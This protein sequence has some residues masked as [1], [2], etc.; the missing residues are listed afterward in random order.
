[1]NSH[2]KIHNY[3]AAV[4][5]TLGALLVGFSFLSINEQIAKELQL[6]QHPGGAG[7]SSLSPEARES[8]QQLN[9]QAIQNQQQRQANSAQNNSAEGAEEGAEATEEEEEREPTPCEDPPEGAREAYRVCCVN[10]D[11]EAVDRD[12]AYE[13]TAG[14]PAGS[15]RVEAICNELTDSNLDDFTRSEVEQE[16]MQLLEEEGLISSPLA[17]GGGLP[18]MDDFDRFGVD[19]ETDTRDPF[20]NS[21][22]NL[23]A[24][25][26]CFAVPAAEFDACMAGISN[27]NQTR[28]I[29]GPDQQQI[30]RECLNAAGDNSAARS[31]CLTPATSER[32]QT[33]PSDLDTSR[34]EE[35]FDNSMIPNRADVAT[36]ATE[37]GGLYELPQTSDGRYA[38]G[39]LEGS[40]RDDVL[41][42]NPSTGT[43]SVERRDSV[44]WSQPAT[45]PD[46]GPLHD[47]RQDLEAVRQGVPV[48][49]L[50]S[51]QQQS[52]SDFS[53]SQNNNGQN[54][55]TGPSGQQIV[56][57]EQRRSGA[58][59][60]DVRSGEGYSS[61]DAE[62]TVPGLVT[63]Y[64]TPDGA[65]YDEF[66][67]IDQ[68]QIG[69]TSIPSINDSSTRTVTT[70]SPE[71]RGRTLSLADFDLP[72]ESG[73][74]RQPTVADSSNNLSDRTFT[75]DDVV[76]LGPTD[77][78]NSAIGL[79]PSVGGAPA[80]DQ[81]P[82]IRQHETV[83][84]QLISQGHEIVEVNPAGVISQIPGESGF[85]LNGE[86]GRVGPDARTS[87]MYDWTNNDG[88]TI[89]LTQN[90][91]SNQVTS[92]EQINLETNQRQE[93][94][95]IGNQTPSAPGTLPQP[96]ADN[97]AV[98]VDTNVQQPPQPS[99]DRNFLQS[100][101]RGARAVGCMVVSCPPVQP[102]VPA[103][104]SVL[105]DSSSG[106]NLNE[107]SGSDIFIPEGG[108]SGIQV[109]DATVNFTGNEQTPFLVNG[110][111]PVSVSTIRGANPYTEFEYP[112]GSIAAFDEGNRIV[113]V[114]GSEPVF[115]GEPGQESAVFN[116]GG[117]RSPAGGQV[118]D[119]PTGSGQVSPAPSA[120]GTM[121]S[122]PSEGGTTP[123]PAA[124]STQQNLP[125][126]SSSGTIEQPRLPRPGTGSG[127]VQTPQ[128]QPPTTGG[129]SQNFQPST[130]GQQTPSS[131][132]GGGMPSQGG[133]QGGGQTQTPPT[134]QQ[135]G[136]NFLTNAFGNIGDLFSQLMGMFGLGNRDQDQTGG[137]D[138]ITTPEPPA[139]EPQLI[140]GLRM[141]NTQIEE[142]DR[143]IILSP[144]DEVQLLWASV[145]TEE[146]LAIP[147]QAVEI[148]GT[149]GVSDILN[150]SRFTPGEIWPIYVI[151]TIENSNQTVIEKI[152]V[153]ILDDDNEPAS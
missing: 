96:S 67:P 64:R 56:L 51:Q 40:G 112:D 70:V 121:P 2:K 150:L 47:Y 1:M 120:P 124:P 11:N 22:N 153:I 119:L 29:E 14:Q 23:G 126:V 137:G 102:T 125:V 143:P 6:A 52:H 50:S 19:P 15:E 97:T 41:L 94:R 83:T 43:T 118:P 134:G 88:E 144:N 60:V 145:G 122:P 141:G 101:A 20:A 24:E 77:S 85:Y 18:S 61:V 136:G 90:K 45:G 53:F 65:T 92:V 113:S 115:I 111:P 3:L 35:P 59:L 123:R 16:A 39:S 71:E 27:E 135:D 82:V 109:G 9:Q 108:Q 48:S 107:L 36:E 128:V 28:P 103:S 26:D 131:G 152:D 87:N 151:C 44:P 66:V 138:R 148:S 146:C 54:I 116:P 100:I 72:P 8:T 13:G 32:P 81:P 117:A 89:R 104:P 73:S 46:G 74:S 114:N 79:E 142:P 38:I 110:Q 69:Q 106:S 129:G 25:A 98:A 75:L 34:R 99:D 49:E 12:V 93:L 140:L 78:S 10:L 149:E 86:P 105:T 76:N 57:P 95:P 31:N 33:R 17:G 68:G 84:S 7:E 139:V 5:F 127:S 55:V 62:S 37:S 133:G 42:Y 80:I 21:Q 132:V 63:T 30:I 91:I 130:G 58:E 147:S 4:T